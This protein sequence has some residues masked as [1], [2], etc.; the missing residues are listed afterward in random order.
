MTRFRISPA[1]AGTEIRRLLLAILLQ[2]A[3]RDERARERARL[4][5]S[6]AAA[7]TG[8]APAERALCADLAERIDGMP[9]PCAG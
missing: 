5:L 1:T 6:R 9:G 8:L 7:H 4:L 2:L 3:S